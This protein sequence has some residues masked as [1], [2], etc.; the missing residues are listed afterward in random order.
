MQL[1][2]TLFA[3]ATVQIKPNLERLLNLPPRALTKEVQMC[4]DLMKL[5]IES[6]VVCLAL[7][8][9]ETL[10][11][12][13]LLTTCLSLATITNCFVPADTKFLRTCCRSALK[14]TVSLTT[15]HWFLPMNV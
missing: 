11:Q 14:M 4:Q 7:L 6:V 13:C 8:Q 9:H 1:S 12:L 5:F 10:P 3:V 15:K 2:G